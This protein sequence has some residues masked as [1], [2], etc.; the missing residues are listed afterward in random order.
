MSVD[1]KQ[2]LRVIA[3]H[4]LGIVP[5]ESEEKSVKKQLESLPPEEAR[6][7]KRKFRKL[8]KKL[9][10]QYKYTIHEERMGNGE[11]KPD[12]MHILYRKR[13]V[14]ANIE[15]W[16]RNTLKNLS[17]DTENIEGKKDQ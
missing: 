17:R 8:W 3:F 9:A 6:R 5:I 14:L 11:Y 12:H 1:A 16:I 2:P 15:R 10:K 13:M 4:T 7:A